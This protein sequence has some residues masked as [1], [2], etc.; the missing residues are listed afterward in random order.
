MKMR[1]LFALV[2]TLWLTP[3][4]AHAQVLVLVHGYLGQGGS[5]RLSGTTHVL[6]R[7]G[8]EDGGHLRIEQ[9]EVVNYRRGMSGQDR[10]FYTLDMPSEAPVM[11]QSK[12]LAQYMKAIGQQHPGE[13]LNIAGF[14]A[15]GLIGRTYMVMRKEDEPRVA[16]LIT[17]STPHLGT[18]LAEVGSQLQ[19]TPLSWVAPFVGAGAFNRSDVLFR[20]MR[21]EEPGNFL[22]WLNRQVHPSANYVSI[23]KGGDSFLGGD[24]VVPAYSQNMNNVIAIRGM[25]D[26]IR[27]TGGHMLT[28]ND[29]L[30]LVQI[31]LV[32]RQI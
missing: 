16:T 32:G 10:T 8:W 5:W 26:I 2:L 15:G 25:S 14:S 28:Y 12:I 30:L 29:A 6:D 24:F 31:M 23:V 27:S 1:S 18:Q 17:I 13:S 11:V 20:D 7:A 3:M 4:M 19:Q 21:P 9:G 22:Y